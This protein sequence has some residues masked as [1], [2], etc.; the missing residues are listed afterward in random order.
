MDIQNERLAALIEFAKQTAL[1]KKTPLQNFSQHK[2]FTRTEERIKGLPGVTFNCQETEFDEVWLRLDRLHET[3]PP[4]PDSKLLN[5]WIDLPRAPNKEPSLK[6]HAVRQS[7]I[8]IGA[9]VVSP[10]EP[11]A[12]GE[13][14]KDK[15][16]SIV[17]SLDDFPDSELLKGQLKSYVEVVWRPW[18]EREKEVRKSIALYSELFMLSQKMQGNLVDSQLELVWGVGVALWTLS[19]GAL[20]YPLLTQLVEISLNETTMALEIRPR[21]SEPRL[22]V[23]IYASMDNPGVAKLVETSKKF[24]ESTGGVLNPFEPSTF[25][26]LLQSAATFL[27]ASGTYWP[28]QTTA[29]DRSLP[30][31]TENLVVTDTWVLLAR[32]RTSNLLVQDLERFEAK[33]AAENLGPLPDAVLSLV[34]EPSS[35]NE[36]VT[37]PPFRGLSVVSGSGGGTG[38]GTG[39]VSELYFPMAYNDEQVQIIL[40]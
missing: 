12:E 33:L 13:V 19:S 6:T 24:F 7:L 17:I 11:V 21:S 1:L 9:L 14:V 38:S 15:V 23:D 31:S 20:A 18:A 30:K 39:H 5:L 8:D 26:P 28:P 36:E 2:D 25:E 10:A 3:R 32:P 34:T 35:E 27:D 22:E 37:L 29:D 16:E 4:V 40:R